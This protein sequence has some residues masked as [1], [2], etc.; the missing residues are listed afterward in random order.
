MPSSAR[1]RDLHSFP[2]RRSSD[3]VADAHQAT[4]KLS[5]A[6]KT[7][8]LLMLGQTALVRGDRELARRFYTEAAEADSATATQAANLA[9]DDGDRSEEHTSELQS[10]SD[11]VCRLLRATEIST[12]SL[13]DALPISSPTPIKR[14]ASFQRRRRPRA[15][16]CWARPRSFAAT[17]SWL[18]GSTPRQPRPI[19]LRRLRQRTWQ[20]MTATD[21]KS[22]R[23]N[24]SH[25]VISYAVFCAPPRSPLFPYTTLFRS[26]R[27]RPSSDGQAFNGAEDRAPA[28]A[29]PDRARS[30]RP[31]VGSQVLHRGS[32]GRFGYGDSG[33]EPGSR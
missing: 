14:R 24:S 23:L 25:T 5:T 10:H 20:P 22:I 3:L 1:H 4:G 6:Q 21:R 13:H 28:H 17:A 16:S 7:A 32:R 26:R 9:A 15:C 29:G 8:R 30:R 11:L 19:R 12:L 31:R 18:A 2:T 33:S 27:R